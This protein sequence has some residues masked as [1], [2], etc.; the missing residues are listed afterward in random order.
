M[1][2]GFYLKKNRRSIPASGQAPSAATVN[3]QVA[4]L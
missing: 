3:S 1:T 2:A 4:R